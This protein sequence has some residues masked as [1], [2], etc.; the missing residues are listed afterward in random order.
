MGLIALAPII[1]VRFLGLQTLR[2]P[3]SGHVCVR[4]PGWEHCN[5]EAISPPGENIGG[6]NPL[7]QH[8]AFLAIS[9]SLLLMED[10]SWP[11]RRSRE[12]SQQ[13][14]WLWGAWVKELW[15]WCNEDHPHLCFGGSSSLASKEQSDFSCLW[16]HHPSFFQILR[17]T[18]FCANR[19]ARK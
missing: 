1:L 2:S 17:F 7:G 10:C 8:E 15:P 11:P 19:W 13:Q 4:N 6:E 18:D 12:L 14:V 3:T 9:P 16:H 5:S